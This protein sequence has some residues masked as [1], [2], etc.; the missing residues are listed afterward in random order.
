MIVREYTFEDGNYP[1][2]GQVIVPMPGVAMIVRVTVSG[3]DV[4]ISA[5]VDE[6]SI[7]EDIQFQ[8]YETDH[9]IAFPNMNQLE[10]VGAA[11][12]QS[13]NRIMHLWKEST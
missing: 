9:E 7:I 12:F 3:N 13:G 6:S 1:G 11:E 4:V 5:L 2:G 8:Y 10:Y